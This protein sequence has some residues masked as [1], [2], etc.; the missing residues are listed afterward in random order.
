M[1]RRREK[2]ENS[3]EKRQSRLEAGPPHSLRQQPGGSRMEQK[4]RRKV[5]AGRIAAKRGNQ[6][7]V[8]DT[9]PL[10]PED[11]IN[12]VFGGRGGE[13]GDSLP[14]GRMAEMLDEEPI[15]DEIIGMAPVNEVYGKQE[16]VRKSGNPPEPPILAFRGEHLQSEARSLPFERQ[17]RRLG[18]AAVFH[19]RSAGDRDAKG[20]RIR[21]DSYNGLE[22]FHATLGQGRKDVACGA[23]T[24]VGAVLRNRNQIPV[25]DQG[26]L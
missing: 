21:A 8:K 14:P 5:K 16:Q 6:K 7:P 3:G 24:R 10:H 1:R 13:A 17:D 12:P 11:L 4:Q 9:Q 22:I 15:I 26:S 23:Q 25:S 2:I 20:P 19:F 18:A